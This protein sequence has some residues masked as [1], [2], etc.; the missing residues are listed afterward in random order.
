MK[1]AALS[2]PGNNIGD[3]V[4]S[5]AVMQHLPA[6]DLFI[7]RDH[8]DTY[9]GDRALL[10]MN[11]WFQNEIRN[12]PPS[13]R[14][15]P[16]FFGFHVQKR[17]RETVAQNVEYLRRHAPIGC[18]DKATMEFIRSLGV[19]AYFSYCATLTFDAP[20][21]R[22]AD[23][24]YLV[25]AD[26]NRPVGKIDNPEGLAIRDV[27]HRLVAVPNDLRIE[28][29]TEMVRTYGRTARYVVTS[30]IHCAM[31]CAAMGIPVV[32]TGPVGRRTSVID[33]AGI[34]RLPS[35]TLRERISGPAK[36]PLPKP[37]DIS[38]L[39][40]RIVKDLRGRIEAALA[41]G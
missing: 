23:S 27:S 17:M 3:D 19:E 29:A 16:L 13:D 7:P 25:E 2:W 4:Q 24:I 15:V 33:E 6:V 11:G 40:A 18:R 10:I 30:R 39:K 12:W 5:V 38:D 36:L 14:I 26:R 34:P 41:A 37:V 32:F 22:N 20:E 28:Y 31:P 35:L 21:D 9:R 1:I 8:L